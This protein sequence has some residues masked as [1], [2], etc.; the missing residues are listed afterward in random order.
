MRSGLIMIA[1]ALALGA[2]LPAHDANPSYLLN[3]AEYLRALPA[4]KETL[5]CS[6]SIAHKGHVEHNNFVYNKTDVVDTLVRVSQ[7]RPL[8]TSSIHANQGRK[9]DPLSAGSSSNIDK[10]ALAVDDRHWIEELIKHT[11]NYPWQVE[12]YFYNFESTKHR[13]CFEVMAA[14]GIFTH[15][16]PTLAETSRRLNGKHS[17]DEIEAH[18]GIPY[19]SPNSDAINKFTDKNLFA[20]WMREKGLEA[21]VPKVFQTPDE[22]TFPC[23]VRTYNRRLHNPW[24]SDYAFMAISLI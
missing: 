8:D 11:G 2:A 1:T 13:L 18:F 14:K 4:T 24:S 22:A 5:E 7:Q 12:I 3:A 16:V 17:V 15:L 19:V 21:F 10:S 6:L 9:F 20:Q 23:M